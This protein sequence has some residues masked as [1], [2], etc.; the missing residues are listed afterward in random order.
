M[1]FILLIFLQYRFWF[2][3]GG[4]RDVLHLKNK[5][6]LQIKENGKLKKQNDALLS[7][8]DQLKNNQDATE[9][10]AR[11]ELGMIK[12]GETFYQIVK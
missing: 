9:F 2:E 8:V 1:L 4:V 12:K 11:S 5:L 6:V 3:S 7:Q 10:R